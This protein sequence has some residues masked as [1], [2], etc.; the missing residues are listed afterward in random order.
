MPCFGKLGNAFSLCLD[1]LERTQAGKE[2][3]G[4]EVSSL[5]RDSR[6]AAGAARGCIGRKLGE[7][8]PRELGAAALALDADQGLSAKGALAEGYGLPESASGRA[9]IPLPGFRPGRAWAP[10]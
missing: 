7:G 8:A 1:F 3:P 2:S 5:A 10:R 6:E 4:S 9:V